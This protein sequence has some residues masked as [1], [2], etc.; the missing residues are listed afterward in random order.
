MALDGA[1]Y[2][3]REWNISSGEMFLS[4]RF[5]SMMGYKDRN[6]ANTYKSWENN[7]HP[8]DVDLVVFTLD[9]YL[10]RQISEFSVEYRFRHSDGSYR[11]IECTGIAHWDENGKALRVAGSNTDISERKIFEQ[12]LEHRLFHDSL[13]EL[14]NRAMFNERLELAIH[15]GYRRA[16]YGYAVLLVGIDQFKKINDSYGH[17]EGD[18]FLKEISSRLKETIRSIDIVARL[19]GDE[20]VILLEE[21]YS[22]NDI[23]GMWK[24]VQDVF[25]KPIETKNCNKIKITA[26]IGAVRD[27]SGY[28]KPENILRDAHVALTKAKERGGNMLVVFRKNMHEEIID[29]MRIESDLL[30]AMQTNQFE[31]YYQ[32]IYSLYSDSFTGFEALIRWNKPDTG[33]VGPDRFIPVAEDTGL[34]FQLNE[35]VINEVCRQVGEWKP[36]IIE[37]NEFSVNININSRQFM[38]CG[39]VDFVKQTVAKYGIKPEWLKFEITESELM[40]DAEETV[41]K[42]LSLSRFGIDICI[43]DFGTGYSSLSYLQKFPVSYLKIDRGFI[44]GGGSSEDNA[45]IVKTIIA[46]GKNLRM[47]TVAEGVENEEQLRFLRK[48]CCDYVQGFYFQRPVRSSEASEFLVENGKRQCTA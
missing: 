32:P 48:E 2:G 38:Q 4:D 13:T 21:V 7:I 34:I 46:L 9:Q 27:T 31:M 42:L 39:F 41:E 44:S 47:K 8:E 1:N 37:K 20:F 10:L 30:A 36:K 35:W 12:E 23:S 28:D 5:V 11:W 40:E 19:S 6:F 15:R 16:D 25:R 18:L 26:S 14:P 3:L 22:H 33:L 43:D 45:E 17:T 29:S 24:R